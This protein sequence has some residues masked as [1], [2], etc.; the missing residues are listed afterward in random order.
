MQITVNYISQGRML[1]GQ[2]FV[3]ET[4]AGL[5]PA[6]LFES[7]VTGATQRI[8]EVI[9]REVAD[10]GFVT[11]VVDHRYFSEDETQAEPWE[12]PSKRI[13][14]VKA[15]FHYLQDHPAVD[16]DNI[17]GVGVSVG[18]EYMAEVCRSSSI[19][20]GLVMLQGPFDDS[21]NA[22]SHL[23]IPSIVIDDTHL[24]AAVDE[25]VLWVRTLLNGNSPMN[26]R[27]VPW[28]EISE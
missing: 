5:Q 3:S 16:S 18:A 25:I 7:A 24:E 22:A 11:M 14:D 28:N 13:E 20:K 26:S 21:Q 15:A 9:A 19:C 4:I 27:P 6:L 23:D 17:I 10:Q 2:L 1:E 12:S 8:T